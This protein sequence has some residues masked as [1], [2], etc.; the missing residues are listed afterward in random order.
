MTLIVGAYQDGE[1]WMGAD[2]YLE[3]NT[4]S[5]NQQRPKIIRKVEAETNR[6]VL[7]G[8][9]GEA[10]LLQIVE[11]RYQ[12]RTRSEETEIFEH[13]MDGIAQPLLDAIR[14]RAKEL[15]LKKS[16]WPLGRFLIGY[17]DRLFILDRQFYVVET[18]DSFAAIGSGEEPALGCLFVTQ[19]GDLPLHERVHK[20]ME[21]GAKYSSQVAPPFHIEK[22]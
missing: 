17:E 21:A 16:K 7:I 10:S 1:L 12:V 2:S 13:V 14:I 11:F 3:H 5:F 8:C 19:T 9:C 6:P 15:N 20:A 22:L 4:I 18:R